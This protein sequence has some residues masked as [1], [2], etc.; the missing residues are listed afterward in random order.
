MVG[1]YMIRNKIN[2]KV[3][4]GQTINIDNRWMQH[5]SRLKCQ[6]HENKHLQSAYD[7]YGK[8]AFE[9]ILLEECEE[10]ELNDK[11]KFYIKYYDSY[12]SGYNQDFGGQGC[13]G[14]T[15][16]EEEILKMRYIQNPKAILQLDKELNIVNEW[17]SCSH[18]GK[19][20]GFS[21][22]SIKACCNRENRQ[23]TIGGFYWIYKTDYEKF[24]SIGYDFSQKRNKKSLTIA[25]LVDERALGGDI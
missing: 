8:D 4:I 12:Y 18:A 22:R 21:A 10:N 9:Y 2:N 6:S 15:H 24:Q 14:Y 1:I 19:T 3:Y 20:L 25:D 7:L 16:S 17:I 11:E 5:R 13:S 23:K